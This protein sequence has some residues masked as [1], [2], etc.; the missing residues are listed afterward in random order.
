MLAINDK[1]KICIFSKGK[2]GTTTLQNQLPSEWKSV[3]E[4]DVDWYGIGPEYFNR[5]SRQEEIVEYLYEEGYKLYFIIRDPWSR[6]VS[7]FKEIL[8]DHLGGIAN[9]DEFSE[10]WHKIVYEE[11]RLIRCI[12]RLFYLSEFICEG[13]QEK[14]HNWGRAFTVHTNYHTCN[15]LD[16]CENFD[17]I[18]IDSKNLDDFM[19]KLNIAPGER[20]NTSHKQDLICVGKALKKCG[21]YYLIEKFLEPEIKRYQQIS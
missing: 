12:D 1:E 2:T 6:Y 9:E 20:A 10:L 8:Q 4:A 14:K 3:G 21:A 16:F 18:Y 13:T 11:E 5:K 15:Y 19:L 17:A 7:G